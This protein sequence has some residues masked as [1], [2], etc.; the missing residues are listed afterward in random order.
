M[1]VENSPDHVL[2]TPAVLDMIYGHDEGDLGD[3]LS[4]GGAGYARRFLGFS[5]ELWLQLLRETFA[6]G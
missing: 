3:F 2:P 4:E 6:G 5:P 1:N